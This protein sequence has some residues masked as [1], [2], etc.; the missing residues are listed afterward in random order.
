[1]TGAG[2]DIIRRESRAARRLGRLLR[3]EAAGG[4]RRRPTDIVRRLIERRDMI[5]E[6]LLQLDVMRRSLGS[7]RTAALEEAL[8]EL[9]HNVNTALQFAHERMEQI[10]GDLRMRHG[11]GLRTGIS[12]AVVGQLLGSI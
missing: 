10:S 6:Q 8:E 12:N 3:V 5:I 7:P 4:F 1:V 9:A 2:A 11:E